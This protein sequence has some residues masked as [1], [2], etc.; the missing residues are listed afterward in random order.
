MKKRYLLIS[1]VAMLLV[2]G[3]SMLFS[4]AS[5]SP[6]S[7]I[8]GTW[9]DLFDTNM[10]IFTSDN[11][12]LTVP[13]YSIDFMEALKNANVSETTTSTLYEISVA[14]SGLN[15]KYKFVKID[16]ISLNYS[17]TN[18][19]ITVGPLVLYKR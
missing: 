7:W 17:V 18:N 2:S 10:Y 13:P 15:A 4:E 6:P 8:I 3:C 19:G 14:V 1:L 16:D 9:A 12:Y 11:V 5:F